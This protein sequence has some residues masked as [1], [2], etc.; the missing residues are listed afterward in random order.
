[1]TTLANFRDAA[2]GKL[3]VPQQHSILPDTSS[4]G[5]SISALF[6]IQSYFNPTTA[7]NL[8]QAAAGILTQSRNEPI[9]NSTLLKTNIG[10]YSFGLHPSSQTPVA[11]QPT[12]GGQNTSPQAIILRPGQIYRPHGKPGVGAGNF[13]GFNWGL[14]FGWLGGGLATLYVFPS[15]DADV[16]WPGNAEVLFHRQTIRVISIAEAETLLEVPFN[17]PLR[18]PWP[19]AASVFIS[20][21]PISQA[22]SPIISISKPTRIEMSLRSNGLAAPFPMRMLFRNTTDFGT[23]AANSCRFVDYTWGTFT[24]PIGG[25][26]GNNNWPIVELTGEMCRVAADDGG[27]VFVNIS[28][29][30]TLDNSQ[31]DVIRYGEI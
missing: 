2:R 31:V 4:P 15:A 24:S 7:P 14:P 18:F 25:I 19:H 27:V 20:S 8:A 22:G 23:S 28:G 21:T 13:S 26:F 5:V 11:I 12:V 9:V 17:W 29:D 16:A 30:P 1:M 10:G 3:N 6:D